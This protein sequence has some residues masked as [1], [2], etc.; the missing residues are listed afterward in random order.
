MIEV[1]EVRV[2]PQGDGWALE[3]AGEERESVDT[4]DEAIRRGRKLAVLEHGEL[5]ILGKF[6]PIREK[7]SR[8]ARPVFRL[9]EREAGGFLDEPRLL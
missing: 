8:W 3:V 9:A 1:I 6:G 5:V 2:V 4:R 7:D